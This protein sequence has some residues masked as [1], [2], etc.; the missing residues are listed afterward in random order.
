MHARF[1]IHAQVV[2]DAA[3]WFCAQNVGEFDV[4]MTHAE[5]LIAVARRP[6]SISRVLMKVTNRPAARVRAEY[7]EFCGSIGSLGTWQEPKSSDDD[8]KSERRSG[9]PGG[10]GLRHRMHAIDATSHGYDAV[11]SRGTWMVVSSAR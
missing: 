7:R 4:T 8:Q 11:G 9:V 2:L 5:Y 1:V 10:P 6:D 3:G